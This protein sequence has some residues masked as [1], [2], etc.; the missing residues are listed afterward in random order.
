MNP[1]L[2]GVAWNSAHNRPPLEIPIN[3][4]VRYHWHTWRGNKSPRLTLLDW[5]PA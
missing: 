4:A 3:I 2:E 1:D 5:R